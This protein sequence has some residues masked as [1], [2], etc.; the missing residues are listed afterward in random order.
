MTTR[1]DK[2]TIVHEI[3]TYPDLS[4]IGTYADEPG[5][6]DGT[7]DRQARGDT[8]YHEWHYFIAAMSGDPNS[9]EQD[10]QR[11]ESYNNRYWCMLGIYARAE[12]S[13]DT[14]VGNRRIEY[15]ESSGLL[16]VESD[17]EREYI[18]EVEQEELLDLKGHLEHFGVDTSN[19]DE[20]AAHADTRTVSD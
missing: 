15:F 17:S 13:Y 2:I 8:R 11:M 6:E 20:L 12:V 14:G 4:Y 19:F 16:G 9:V 1:I 18:A 10:Y 5:P 7:I 3:D